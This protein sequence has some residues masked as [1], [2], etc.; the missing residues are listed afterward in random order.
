MFDSFY[1]EV[2][3]DSVNVTEEPTLPCQRKGLMMVQALTDMKLP[4]IGTATCTLK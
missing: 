2:I 4:K 3:H 1:S